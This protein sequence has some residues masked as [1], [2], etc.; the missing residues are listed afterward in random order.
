MYNR[1]TTFRQHWW[2]LYVG[3]WQ[4]IIT[5]GILGTRIGVCVCF[6]M[7]ICMYMCLGDVI[8]P[9]YWDKQNPPIIP[10]TVCVTYMTNSVSSGF[11]KFNRS[12]RTF[13]G[14]RSY[15]VWCRSVRWYIDVVSYWSCNELI[16][17]EYIHFSWQQYTQWIILNLSLFSDVLEFARE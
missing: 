13:Y 9:L 11:P 2:Q 4:G 16:Q 6:C 15:F 14:K 17:P 3:E 8:F 1:L 12:F 5:I 10:F 7:C